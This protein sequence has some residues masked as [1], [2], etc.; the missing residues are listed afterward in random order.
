ML[1]SIHYKMDKKNNN[2]LFSYY[3]HLGTEYPYYL[4][5]NSD[6]V[7]SKD[8]Q[9]IV[10][11]I[12]QS[13]RA[14][15]PV[16]LVEVIGCS[17]LL[18]DRTL[19]K[20]VKKAPWM[21]K[22][23]DNGVWN[24]SELPN[25]SDK[26][27]ESEKVAKLLKNHLKN[28]MLK[29]ID[30]KS[31]I[32]IL[33]SGGLDS[34]IVA[35]I[36][37][38]LQLSSDF[39][40][41]VVALTWGIAESR[42]VIYASEICKK[43]NW[44]WHHLKLD[45]EVLKSNIYTVG[46]IGAEFSPLHLH[47]MSQVREIEGI[48]AI[49]AGSYGDSVGRAEFSGKHLLSIKGT[50]SNNLNKFGL[51]KNEV[52][53][54]NITNVVNDAFGYKHYIKR[55]KEYQYREIEQEMHYMRRKLQACMNY[56]SEKIPVYQLFT[57][58]KTFGFMWGLDPSIRNDK[59]YE[60]ILKELPNDLG[61]IPWARTGES[62]NSTVKDNNNTLKNHH[63]YGVWLRNDLNTFI[64]ELVTNNR[65]F[66]LGVFNEQA[67]LNLL[68]IWPKSTTITTNQIDEIISWLA[69][70]SLFL[71]NFNIKNSIPH[72]SNF[73]DRLNSFYG[74][75]HARIYQIAREKQRK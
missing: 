64:T 63:K 16:G 27:L 55:T 50:L 23:K 42:D 4:E 24:Y 34:R 22:I 11:E 41:N 20:G 62:L 28:E 18:S 75:S 38:E 36:L 7:I 61:S 32:G 66:D 48:D 3:D 73:R 40:G 29:Y 47:A 9:G 17:Y 13:Q 25:H 67:L 58:P 14:I 51:L 5:K 31:T 6:I 15:D 26:K 60:I 56:I 53:E 43:F 52:I 59:I 54:S 10:S 70:L 30:Q 72:R 68:R 2:E 74:T 46:R 44:E 71:E 12:P 33:L 39:N 19:I 21:G 65:I 69:S 1:V 8:L 57:D 35:G 45:A 49:I 37:R